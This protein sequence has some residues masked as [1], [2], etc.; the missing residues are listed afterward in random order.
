MNN[1]MSFVLNG[2]TITI[3]SFSEEINEFFL[4]LYSSYF[5]SKPF[6][7]NNYIN[8]IQNF[9]TTTPDRD[10]IHNKYFN[11]F[12]PI[13]K[14]LLNNGQFSE[15]ELIWQFALEPILIFEKNNPK[16]EIHKGTAYYFWGMTSLLAGDLDKGFLLMHQAVE[17]NVKTS[18]CDLPDTPAMA[19][20]SLNFQKLDQ[21]FRQWVTHQANYLEKLIKIY[22]TKYSRNFTIDDFQKKFLNTSPNLDITFLFVY[23]LARLERVANVPTNTLKSRFSSQL[24]INLLFDLSVVIETTTKVKNTTG[25]S[26][27]HHAN[28]LTASINQTL[29]EKQ[30]GDINNEFKINFDSTLA[31]IVN[32]LF[33]LPDGTLLSDTQTDIV[34]A[35]GIRNKGAHDVAFSEVISDNFLKISESIFNVL[36]FVIEFLF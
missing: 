31:L 10:G 13:W 28:F 26:F 4:N 9:L 19:F 18:K 29:S 34:I 17:E 30:L 25:K 23:T 7:W 35:Y 16:R 12:S 32:N 27:I 36:F 1:L 2:R 3:F 24:I 21:A 11:N 15:A 20:A 14:H 6:K 5:G 22:S 8:L 33:T